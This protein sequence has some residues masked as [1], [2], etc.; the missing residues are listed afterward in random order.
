ME[1]I[2]KQVKTIKE[3][4]SIFLGQFEHLKDLYLELGKS[5]I[6]EDIPKDKW[7]FRTDKLANAAWFRLLCIEYIILSK[8]KTTHTSPKVENSKNNDD[9]Q[10]DKDNKGPEKKRP[11]IND[12]NIHP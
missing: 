11:T 8:A 10:H 6:N 9:E 7:G 2:F 3:N 5:V 12:D 4:G 1:D